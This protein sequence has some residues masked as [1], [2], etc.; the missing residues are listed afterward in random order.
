MGDNYPK[1]NFLNAGVTPGLLFWNLLFL[2]FTKTILSYRKP[3][4]FLALYHTVLSGLVDMVMFCS[5]FFYE[6]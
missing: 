4:G 1:V 5:I 3:N 2:I 6:L